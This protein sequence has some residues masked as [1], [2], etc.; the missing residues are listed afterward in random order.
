MTSN[1]RDSEAVREREAFEWP[2]PAAWRDK[3]ET[4]DLYAHM[5]D[6]EQ[7]DTEAL[8]TAS[9]VR[10]MLARAAST[11][12]ATDERRPAKS[13]CQNGGDVCLA[14]NRD[15]ICCPEDSCDID[16]GVRAA[17]P[18]SGLTVEQ[19]EQVARNHGTGGWQSLDDM[20]RFA[21]ALLAEQSAAPM[22][23]PVATLHDDGH[24]VWNPKVRKPDGYDRAGWSMSV[25]ALPRASEQADEAVTVTAA[26]ADMF[27]P[28]HDGEQMYHSLDDAVTAAFEDSGA[29]A[30]DTFTFT[31]AAR[32]PKVTV[33]IIEVTENGFEWEE[34][35]HAKEPQ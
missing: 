33:R 31:C 12:T 1:T 5:P 14:G 20:K 22:A 23:E 9:D 35:D 10:E 25:Y 27:W 16:D 28:E 15:G 19:I 26:D 21:R 2:K 24:Y 7:L 18:Q 17:A 13:H 3:H 11:A 34:V 8:Y 30:G 32:L 29:D 4:S 6:P